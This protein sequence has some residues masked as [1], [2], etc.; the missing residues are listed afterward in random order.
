MYLAT[1]SLLPDP[2]EMDEIS[3]L[4][5]YYM[6]GRTWVFGL[7]A[8]S[9]LGILAGEAFRGYMPWNGSGATRITAIVLYLLLAWSSSV[10][11]HAI[12][13]GGGFILFGAFIAQYTLQLVR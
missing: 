10:R 3:S 9:I 5:D 1:S 6:A 4:L 7:M 12:I 11:V 2:A 8:L 13:T